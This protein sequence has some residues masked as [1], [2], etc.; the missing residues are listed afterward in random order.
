MHSVNCEREKSVANEILRHRSKA[1]DQNKGNGYVTYEMVAEA[2]AQ[3]AEIQNFSQAIEIIDSYFET[4]RFLRDDIAFIPILL[5]YLNPEFCSNVDLRNRVSYSLSKILGDS[6]LYYNL[7]YYLKLHEK[8]YNYLPEEGAF[9]LMTDLLY[10]DAKKIIRLSRFHTVFNFC[11]QHNFIQ[12]VIDL[13]S[14][15]TPQ[16]IDQVNALVKSLSEYKSKEDLEHI[17]PLADKILEIILQSQNLDITERFLV[18]LAIFQVAAKDQ[19]KKYIQNE[20]LLNLLLSVPDDSISTL[21]A[22]FSYFSKI[23]ENISSPLS[24]KYFQQLLMLTIKFINVEN[25]LLADACGLLSYLIR[26]SGV[27]E[28]SLELIRNG[29]FQRLIE[30]FHESIPF[31]TKKNIIDSILAFIEVTANDEAMDFMLSLGSIDCFELAIDSMHE[32]L[33]KF[34]NAFYRILNFAERNK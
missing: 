28:Y 11:I 17:F 30:I 22:V 8:I 32:L 6:Y 20:S 10:Y 2:F 16:L 26:D 24:E 7:I 14:D 19:T 21:K 13:L 27:E 25:I 31:N 1:P 18:S 29:L 5:N 3:L 9:L 23:Y 33:Q 4:R 15:L 12:N 34:F